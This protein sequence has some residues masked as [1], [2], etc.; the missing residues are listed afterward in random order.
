MDSGNSESSTRAC[1]IAGR[2]AN[3][4]SLCSW[5]PAQPW[6]CSSGRGAQPRIP[7]EPIQWSALN[8]DHS[9]WSWG[10]S[11]IFLVAMFKGDL[12]R[13]RNLECVSGHEWE[14]KCDSFLTMVL[15]VC[16]FPVWGTAGGVWG[17]LGAA[18]SG[19]ETLMCSLW[20]YL[21]YLLDELGL[22]GSR[23]GAGVDC[24]N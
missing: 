8:T 4:P 14:E 15:C 7:A 13:T 17:R 1:Y 6:P 23:K 24:S 11:W 18:W 19:S 3:K 22:P 10:L 5:K 21:Q 16:R 9:P 2:Q 20:I 12:Q